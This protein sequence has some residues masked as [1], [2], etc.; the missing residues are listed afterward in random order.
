M[1]DRGRVEWPTLGL[2]L[3]C[4]AVW[5][6]AVFGGLPLWL[7]VPLAGSTIALHSSLCHEAIHGHPFRWRWANEALVGAPLALIVPYARFRDTHLAHHFDARLTDPFDDPESNY[8][9][10]GSWARLPRAVRSVLWFNNTL[11]GRVL[12]GPL[13]GTL[14]W[15]RSDLA[16]L[17]RGVPRVARGWALHRPVAAMLVWII[18][19]GPIPLW[20]YGVAVLIGLGLIRI[21]TFLEHRAHETAGAR[22]AIVEDGGLLSLLFLNNNL[23]VVHHLHPGVPWYQLPALYAARRADYRAHNGGYVYRSYGEVFARHLLRVKDPV[24]HPLWRR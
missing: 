21:R 14:F 11:F 9:D 5:A 8:L 23:H 19:L 4:Y 22:T 12:F 16:A 24:A 7:A 10:G 2:A 15:L 1:S 17:G 6:L 3:L 13:L 18:A 20:A